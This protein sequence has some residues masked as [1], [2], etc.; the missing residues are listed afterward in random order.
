MSI[1]DLK[2]AV[3]SSELGV[4]SKETDLGDDGLQIFPEIVNPGYDGNDQ[5]N[6]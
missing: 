6:P 3:R 2:R 1:G 5:S 4:R